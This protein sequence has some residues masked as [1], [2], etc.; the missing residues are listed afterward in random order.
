MTP[1]EQFLLTTFVAP[2]FDMPVSEFHSHFL[3]WLP[4]GQRTWTARDT[5]IE[6]EKHRELYR[7]S[8]NVNTISDISF[9]EPYRDPV[10]QEIV[11]VWQKRVKFI[12]SEIGYVFFDGETW[13]RRKP[14]ELRNSL[15]LYRVH[16][17]ETY[18]IKTAARA[19]PNRLHDLL[20]GCK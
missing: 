19:N 10:R 6:L 20:A 2:G 1:L 11:D 13:R 17:G 4:S 15:G 16:Q 18:Q 14:P 12:D 9:T 8:G 3:E 7:G 5:G